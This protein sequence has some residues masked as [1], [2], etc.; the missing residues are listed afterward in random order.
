MANS[1]DESREGAGSDDRQ[2]THLFDDH[3]IA[4]YRATLLPLSPARPT[5]RRTFDTAFGSQA[6]FSVCLWPLRAHCRSV[7]HCNGGGSADGY[8]RKE[9]I[10]NK[11]SYLLLMVISKRS[12]S[13]FN[14]G[15][16]C[17]RRLHSALMGG[18]FC[19]H[20]G[21]VKRIWSKVAVKHWIVIA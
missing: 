15:A 1:L 2:V 5:D 12:P 18:D 21:L 20:T 19:R 7:D 11:S 14:L 17:I 8:S 3:L 13:T 16:M 4:Y 9:H 10:C 6:N